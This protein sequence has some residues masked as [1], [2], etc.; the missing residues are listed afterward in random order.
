[1]NKKSIGILL[2]ILSSLLLVAS[3][4]YFLYMLRKPTVPT[5]VPEPPPIETKPTPIIPNT[6]PNPILPISP[7]QPTNPDQT[8]PAED[9]V[10]EEAYQKITTDIWKRWPIITHLVDGG[11]GTNF[12]ISY[13]LPESNDIEKVY[14]IVT[15]KY[16]MAEVGDCN[17]MKKYQKE[18][19]DW[20]RSN[21]TDPSTLK[22]VWENDFFDCL[23]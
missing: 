6:P 18:V 11:E 16:S 8:T 20:I 5:P 19:L 23:K 21:G 2:I 7:N 15:I 1:M 4:V 9:I 12:S 17:A 22:I 10:A 3:I 14:F 13:K